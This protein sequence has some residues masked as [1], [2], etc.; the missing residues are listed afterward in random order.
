MTGVAKNTSWSK[1]LVDLGTVCSVLPRPSASAY[2]TCERIQCGRDLGV[3]LCEA[4]E[5]PRPTSAA[6]P[7]DVWTWVAIDPD[8][9]LVPTFGWL[10]RVT[11]GAVDRVHDR[12]EERLASRVQLTTD[13]HPPYGDAVQAAFGGGVDYAQ[14][15]KTYGRVTSYVLPAATCPAVASRKSGTLP[16]TGNPG[17]RRTSARATSSGRT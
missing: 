9:K 15:I 1:L 5:R 14:L 2:L 7:G 4:E 16:I 11:Y 12:P 3:R 17:P 6:K 8:T 13:A 10:A